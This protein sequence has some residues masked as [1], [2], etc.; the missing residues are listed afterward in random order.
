MCIKVFEYWIFCENWFIY[1]ML[2]VFCELPRFMTMNNL[3]TL[4]LD[5]DEF[6]HRLQQNISNRQVMFISLCFYWIMKEQKITELYRLTKSWIVI[7]NSPVR[8]LHNQDF[9][10]QVYKILDEFAQDASYMIVKNLVWP[11]KE[12]RH[13]DKLSIVDTFIDH[14]MMITI[15]ACILLWKCL[16]KLYIYQKKKHYK[17]IQTNNKYYYQ[18]YGLQ[19]VSSCKHVRDNWCEILKKKIR[20]S[21]YTI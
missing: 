9:S 1:Y 10:R 7:E 5:T 19:N 8:Y 11:V 21:V 14:Q 6:Q 18:W 15:F 4:W 3:S 13:T 16:T 2:R 12:L 17:T 20:S